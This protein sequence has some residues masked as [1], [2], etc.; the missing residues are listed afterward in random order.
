[1]GLGWLVKWRD[2]KGNSFVQKWAK[3]YKPTNSPHVNLVILKHWPN[4][5]ISGE[6]IIIC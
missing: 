5:L 2:A 1:M 6:I 4:N 3:Q